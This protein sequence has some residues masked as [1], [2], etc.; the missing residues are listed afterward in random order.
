MFESSLHGAFGDFVE[1]DALNAGRNRGL[2]FFRLLGFL[3]PS[4]VSIKFA[5]KM[6]GDG[7]ALTIR[8]GREIDGI[9]RRSQL[10]QFGNYFFFAWDDNVICLEIVRGVHTESALGQIFDMPE[11]GFDGEALTKILLDG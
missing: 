2:A 9:G 8:V 1:R 4:A 6:G 3:F 11:R 7:L 10:L 5:G